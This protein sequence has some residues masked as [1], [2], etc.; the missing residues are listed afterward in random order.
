M[1]A[2]WT[3]RPGPCSFPTLQLVQVFKALCV[4]ASHSLHETLRETQVQA[5][6]QISPY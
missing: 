5:Q 2:Q 3:R 6:K 1:A 4:I